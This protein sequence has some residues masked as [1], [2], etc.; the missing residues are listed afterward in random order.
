MRMKNIKIHSLD[1]HF[2]KKLI[3]SYGGNA[4]PERDIPRYHQ[5]SQLKSFDFNSLI[6]KF[7]SSG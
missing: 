6:S 2:G 5:L 7:Y 1:I 4:Q 3:G